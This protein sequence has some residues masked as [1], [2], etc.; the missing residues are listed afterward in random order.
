MRDSKASHGH[1]LMWYT[2]LLH[3]SSSQTE[4]H[5]NCDHLKGIGTTSLHE[6]KKCVYAVKYSH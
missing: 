5:Q 1:Y 4:F 2:T 6:L 3:K